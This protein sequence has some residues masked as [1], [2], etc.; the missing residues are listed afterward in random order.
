MLQI[1]DVNGLCDWKPFTRLSHKSSSSH[2][3]GNPFS[4]ILDDG[5]NVHNGILSFFQ[6][7]LVDTRDPFDW[8]TL[9]DGVDEASVK[10]DTP[11]RFEDVAVELAN[12][13]IPRQK[14][15]VS[16]IVSTVLGKALVWVLFLPL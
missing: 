9:R 14:V 1:P 16:G 15:C 7:F 6:N 12:D 8:D 13:S 4:R 10:L 11:Q 2:V 5:R 3:W